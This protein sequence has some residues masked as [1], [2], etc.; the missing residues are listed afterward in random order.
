MDIQDVIGRNILALE[1]AEIIDQISNMA[2]LR[3][4]T[5]AKRGRI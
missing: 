4:G 5:A 3:K 2:D 1:H